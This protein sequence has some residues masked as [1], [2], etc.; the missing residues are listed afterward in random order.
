[1]NRLTGNQL[2][3]TGGLILLLVTLPLWGA[4]PPPNEARCKNNW[5]L[6]ST[7]DLAFGAFAIESGTGTLQVNSSG[8]LT[9]VGD[10]TTV[11]TA[12]V[13]TFSV[14]IDNTLDRT[15]CGTYPF[16]LSW[17]IAPAPLAGPGT[18]MPLSNV[19]ATEPTLIPTPTA[20]PIVGLTTSSLPVTLTFQGELTTTFPQAAGVYVSP[21]IT[22]ELIQGGKA[23][24]ASG[25]ATATSLSPLSLAESAAMDFGTVAAGSTA[26]SVVLDS[27]G[28]RSV[29][30]DGQILAS[31]PGFPGQFVLT[32]EPS[33]SYTLTISGPAVLTNAGGEQITA[34]GFTHNSSGVVPA[35]GSETFQVGATLN[36]APSQPAGNYST[37]NAGGTPYSITINYN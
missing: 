33:Q 25:V 5:I 35:G 27:S 8:T 11:S 6:T 13:S 22:L 1:M 15:V 32:G 24:P 12:P 16:D 26:S 18:E 21:T 29:S 31:G 23:T 34:T 14:I 3:I 28:V 30:G 7:Q 36:L 4:P 10:I 9:T 17:A 2:T 37:T 19:L 20:L